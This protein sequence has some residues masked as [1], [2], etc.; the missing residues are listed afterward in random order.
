MRCYLWQQK[1]LDSLSDMNLEAI[2]VSLTAETDILTTCYKLFQTINVG[3]VD[4]GRVNH[5]LEISLY[6]LWHKAHI[7]KTLVTWLSRCH[8]VNLSFLSSAYPLII[9]CQIL[10]TPNWA[11][12]H[13]SQ[14]GPQHLSFDQFPQNTSSAGKPQ[15]SNTFINEKLS[16][17]PIYWACWWIL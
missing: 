9:N 8:V 16:R 5:Y 7:Y 10:L 14:P 4:R 17:I 12:C 13:H 6:R 1:L 2:P 15:Y 11:A 3:T